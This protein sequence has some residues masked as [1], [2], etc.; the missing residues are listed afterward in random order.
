MIREANPHD[1][2]AIQEMIVELAVYEKEPDAV[3]ATPEDL[4]RHLFGSD[5][6]LFAH[7][8]ED[9]DGTVV[10]FALWFLN[11]STWLGKHGIYLEDLY[12]KADHRG[13]GYGKALLAHLASICLERGYGRL[14]WWV[15]DWN[16]PARG[17]YESIGAQGL[18]EWIPYRVT[19]EALTDLASGNA[20]R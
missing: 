7:V 20:T 9:E 13:G 4:H 5:P 19:G 10:G 1:V 18:T 11:Y 3:L 16:T 8:A 17:F 6:A 15:L 12:V 2:A 14:E